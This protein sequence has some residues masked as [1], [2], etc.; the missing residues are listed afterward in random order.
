M[1]IPVEAQLAWIGMRLTV[2][3]STPALALATGLLLAAATGGAVAGGMV[4]GA[5]IKNNS[6]TSADLRNNS[7]GTK[8]IRDGSLRADDFDGA[9]LPSGPTGQAGPAGPRGPSGAPGPVGPGAVVG[10]LSP[11]TATELAD[12]TCGLIRGGTGVTA[13]QLTS[14]YVTTSA[15]QALASNFLFV[16]PGALNPTTQG[17]VVGGALLCNATGVAVTLPA[18]WKFHTV[19]N[20]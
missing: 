6:V 12:G 10:T 1:H 4:T 9:T 15:D 16:V 5:Q 18:G 2:P 20:S 11:G 7:V 13:G 3:R 19:L 14:G 17:G 8:D